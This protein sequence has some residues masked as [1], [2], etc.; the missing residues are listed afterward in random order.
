MKV[1]L[2]G[3][4][5][6]EH[7][8]GWKLA[9][10]PHLD[11]LLAAPGNPGLAEVAEVVPEVAADDV[12]AVTRLAAERA[13]DLVVVGPEAP[14]AAGVADALAAERIAVFGPVAA[15]ARLESSKAYAKRVMERAGVPTGRWAGATD[16][17]AAR[18]ALAR[19]GPPYVVKADGLAAGKGVLV[20]D[21][22]VAAEEWVAGCLDGRFGGGRPNGGD[23]GAPGRA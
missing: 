15:A 8:I 9:A 1:L 13:V 3:G 11:S 17:G 5:G 16:A 21:D 4:G 6:R 19:F 2:L 14:L 20:T 18:A 22:P 12:A 7:A 23:R 10:S